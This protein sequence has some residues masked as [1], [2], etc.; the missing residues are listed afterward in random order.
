VAE[1]NEK[2]VVLLRVAYWVGAIFDGLTLVPMLVPRIGARLFGLADFAPGPEYRY[3][4]SLTAALMLGWTLLLLWADR[5][6]VERRGVLPLTVVVVIGLAAA[7]AYAVG[8]G[9]V[10]A[11]RMAPTWIWQ[12][13]ISALFIFAFL[14]SRDTGARPRDDADVLAS[15]RRYEC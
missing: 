4:M 14:R 8:A 11:E 2:A 6:P 13:V 12:G 5:R 15:A 10:S 7:G 9:I 3:A 1:P